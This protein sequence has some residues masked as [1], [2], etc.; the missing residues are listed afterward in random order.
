MDED[1]RGHVNFEFNSDVIRQ[2]LH[3]VAAATAFLGVGHNRDD[4]R[5]LCRGRRMRGNYH[6]FLWSFSPWSMLVSVDTILSKASS[7]S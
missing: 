1:Q 2:D 7:G 5:F 6:Q 3:G 4:S